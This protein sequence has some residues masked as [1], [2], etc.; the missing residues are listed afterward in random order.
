MNE[1]NKRGSQRLRAVRVK[2]VYEPPQRADGARV[3]VDRLWPR[4]L[5]KAQAKIDL[6]LRDVAPS[7]ALRKW[8]AH[9]PAKWPAFQRRYVAELKDK[10]EPLQRL[11]QLTREHR[12][13]TL[14]YA[15][16][17]PDRNNAVVLA[18]VLNK[19]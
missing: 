15:A 16:S 14:V 3:L 2:R 1:G 5:S 18:G 7:D 17:D 12:L 8:F 10:A 4:G 9:E 13:L 19:R 6:W 11:R